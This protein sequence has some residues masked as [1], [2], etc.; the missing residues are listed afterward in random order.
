[1]GAPLPP[2][3]PARR[4]WL[5]LLRVHGCFLRGWGPTTLLPRQRM[6]SAA[7][8]PAATDPADGDIHCASTGPNLAHPPAQPRE[9]ATTI[10]PLLRGGGRTARP[11]PRSGAAPL[12]RS[13]VSIRVALLRTRVQ[14]GR[15]QRCGRERGGVGIGW[16]DGQRHGGE[17]GVKNN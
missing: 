9:R 8:L 11:L 16:E 13:R 6:G 3:H 14:W 15:R 7:L 4:Q 10:T 2:S 17:K 5:A 1:V 12:A